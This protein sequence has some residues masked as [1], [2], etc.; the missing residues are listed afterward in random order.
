M[1]FYKVNE[2]QIPLWSQPNIILSVENTELEIAGGLQDRVA[3]VYGGM[4][5]MN[6]SREIMHKQVTDGIPLLMMP[7]CHL[8]SLPKLISH[9]FLGIFIAIY[10]V[11]INMMTRMF[12]LQSVS[13]PILLIM[14]L[15][16]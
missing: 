12:T 6:F 15:N 1:L 2:S 9:H 16:L 8:C 13:G 11:A 3:Q 5:H 4:L 14:L 10:A 7:F